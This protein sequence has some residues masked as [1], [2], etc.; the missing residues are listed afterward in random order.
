MNL[1]DAKALQIAPLETPTDLRS[2]PL[3]GVCGALNVLLTDVFAL[4]ARVVINN[5]TQEAHH[6]KDQSVRRHQP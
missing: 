5:R 3:H 2:T 4:R 6:G 1:R